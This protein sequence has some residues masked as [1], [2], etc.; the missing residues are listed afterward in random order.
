MNMDAIASWALRAATQRFPVT[1][2]TMNMDAIASRAPLTTAAGAACAK[3]TG[4]IG[5]RATTTSFPLRRTTIASGVV[6][7]EW[8]TDATLAT[9]MGA[10]TT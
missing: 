9:A 3:P 4:V 2:G 7:G 1:S 8:A 10:A 6:T 5:T